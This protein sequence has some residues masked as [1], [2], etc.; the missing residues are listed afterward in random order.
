MP[1]LRKQKAADETTTASEPATQV[2]KSKGFG[3]WKWGDNKVDI[4][5]T[6]DEPHFNG[7]DVCVIL[8]YQKPNE[9]MQ[10]H[11]D[12][13][14]RKYLSEV[15]PNSCVTYHEEKAVYIC[16]AEPPGNPNLDCTS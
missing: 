13:D 12:P 11:L 15:T 5:G 2:A 6:A 8:G 9:T 10:A 3:M 7:K 14:E 1:E 16:S 4:R